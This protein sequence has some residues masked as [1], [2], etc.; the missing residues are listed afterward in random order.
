M[1]NQYQTSPSN[2]QP[3]FGIPGSTVKLI[4]M[5]CMFID[6]FAAIFIEQPLYHNALNSAK[7]QAELDAYL[8]SHNTLVITD[9]ILR[10]IGRIAF[11][12]FA[13]L[14]VEGFLH[15]HSKAKYCRNLFLM[16]LLSEVPFDL[17]FSGSTWNFAHQN[18]LFTLTIGLLTIWALSQ[19]EQTTPSRWL[20]LITT[21]LIT[22]AGCAA[23]YFLHTDYDLYGILAIVLFYLLR[24]Q[25]ITA[26][27]LA[28]A[29]LTL[30]SQSQLFCFL[31]LIPIQKYNGTR[32]LKLK[33]TFY[34]FYPLHL[35]T[36]YAAAYILG[37]AL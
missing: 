11:P 37:Y 6:H 13:F 2:P 34:L 36:L 32:G 21:P 22:A 20:N 26:T 27:I 17:A 33:Y 3:L 10:S 29:A 14:L 4:A 5:A 24:T 18:T 35:L 31:A 9:S 12:L 30:L 7:T 25:R 28:C 16:A 15:T 8:A 1:T 19:A 23:A